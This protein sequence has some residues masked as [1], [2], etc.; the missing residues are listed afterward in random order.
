MGLNLSFFY[1]TNKFCQCR[2]IDRKIII[3]NALWLGFKRQHSALFKT[4]YDAAVGAVCC[5]LQSKGFALIIKVTFFQILNEYS[6]LT[7]VFDFGRTK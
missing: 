1:V 4:K 3:F 6:K 2:F 5:A 7:L